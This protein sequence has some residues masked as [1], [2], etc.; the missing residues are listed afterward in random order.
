VLLA[1]IEASRA[2]ERPYQNDFVLMMVSMLP[3]LAD[4][5]L[6]LDW[7]LA[8]APPKK[9]F[10]TCD[11]PTV[12]T[13]PDNHPPIRGVGIL[14]PGAEKVVPLS[15][16][17]ALLMRDQ[18]RRPTVRAGV[19]DRDRLRDLNESLVGQSER[20][21]FSSSEAL[22]RSLVTS[23]RPASQGPPRVEIAGGPS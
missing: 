12:I 18:S 5:L 6:S 22:L 9:S 10:I 14:T 15:P 2:T 7:I 16:R 21:V 13:R 23:L 19:I 4:K 11:M 20:F 3:E 17:I 8:F 1:G